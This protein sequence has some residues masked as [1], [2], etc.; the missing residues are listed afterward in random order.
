MLLNVFRSTW[1]TEYA[2]SIS[3]LYTDD[4]KSKYCSNPKDIFKSAKIIMKNVTSRS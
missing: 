3:E 1:K 2:K 4:K